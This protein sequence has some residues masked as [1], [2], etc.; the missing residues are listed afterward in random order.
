MDDRLVSHSHS[1]VSTRA[2]QVRVEESGSGRTVL[3]LAAGAHSSSDWDAI[4][5]GLA[6]HFRTVTVDWPGHGESP[7]PDAAWAVSAA[8]FAD[9]VEDVVDAIAPGPVA[10]L[11][12]SVGGFAAARL[13]IRRP[14]Q[15]GALVLVDSA[16]F[17]PPT[18]VTR[19]ISAT[20]GRPRFLRGIY[21]R[22]ARS[23]MRAETEFATAVAETAVANT[24]RAGTTE[25][26]SKL[27]AS[28]SSPAADLRGQ[29]QRITTPTLVVWGRRDPIV[30]LSIGRRV[31][32]A[33]PGARLDVID[34]GH[35]PFA[36]RPEE[37]L[38]AVLPFLRN[39]LEVLP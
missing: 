37:F 14:D 7:L 25:V 1:L 26:I 17:V 6:A 20:M 38:G 29:E 2:G 39:T 12:N 16:G 34:T 15:V 9:V 31:A 24:R 19:L 32:A 5:P 36:S 18:P 10:V 23:Y 4:R 27:W 13:A 33:I 8:G 21:P 3:L 22:F 28:F 30:R 35:V 11:G